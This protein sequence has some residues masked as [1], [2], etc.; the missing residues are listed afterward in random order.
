MN[1]LLERAR[2]L[3]QQKRYDLAL[4]E[5]IEVLSV[6]PNHDEAYI[7]RGLCLA[8]TNNHQDGLAA[9]QRAIAI[10]PESS[11]AYNC[12]AYIYQ[13]LGDL[14]AAKNAVD[15]AIALEPTNPNSR[16]RLAQIV[17]AI[18]YHDKTQLKPLLL[19]LNL[20]V[21]LS[22]SPKAQFQALNKIVIHMADRVLEIDPKNVDALYLRLKALYALNNSLK[23]LEAS[24]YKLLQ[25]EPNH[26]LTYNMLGIIYQKRQRW[27]ESI[28]FFRTA[29][30]IDPNYSDANI[31]LNVSYIKNDKTYKLLCAL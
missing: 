26:M 5:I 31:N 3:Y 1:N 24:C 17:N 7:L 4:R 22:L 16:L 6:E 23:K 18:S 15:R 12:L 20:K 25:I 30:S 28:K 27:S 11:Y 13:I 2:L 8:L 29:L 10:N 21:D 19:A 14:V 9:I